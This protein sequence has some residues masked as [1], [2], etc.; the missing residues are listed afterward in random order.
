MEYKIKQFREEKRMTQ[1]ELANK[2]GVSRAV[3]CGLESGS[4]KVTTTATLIKIA[5]ALEKKVSDI[6]LS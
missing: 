2:S 3:I 4:L 1:Q 5:S 6:F